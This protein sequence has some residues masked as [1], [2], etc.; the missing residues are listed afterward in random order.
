M[1]A[2]IRGSKTIFH[3]SGCAFFHV[4]YSGR[5][6]LL[7]PFCLASSRSSMSLKPHTMPESGSGSLKSDPVI[8]VQKAMLS[9]GVRKKVS[10]ATVCTMRG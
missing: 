8:M 1:P 4:R 2:C 6:S 3:S 9:S 10:M 5:L 7:R